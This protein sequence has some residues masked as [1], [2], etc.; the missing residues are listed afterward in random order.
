MRF[1][2]TMLWTFDRTLGR[3]AYFLSGTLLFFLKFGIDW[4]IA[5]LAFD[6]P[7]TPLNYLIWPNDR[8]LRIFDL[9]APD[10][11]FVLTMLAVS[12]PFIWAGVLLTLHR[13]GDAGLPRGLVLFFFV[14]LVNLL[15]F[16]LLTL[17]PSAPLRV[18]LVEVPAPRLQRL[19]RA[20]LQLAGKSYWR[21]GLVALALS[22]PAM[23]LGVVL[24][25]QVLESYG[26]SLFVGAP[27]ALGLLSVLL[28]GLSRPQP[29]G[30]CLIVAVLAAWLAGLAMLVV[31]LEGLIC[32]IMAAPIVSAL[33]LFGGLVGYLIQ[34]RPW[35]NE[36]AF[37]ALLGVLLLL[38]ALMAAEAA[39]EPDAEVRAVRTAVIVAAP[40]EVVWELVLAFPPLPEP[41]DWFFCTGVAYPQRA[42]IHGHGVGAVRHCI[43]S[44][45]AFVEPIEVWEPPTCLA[46]RVTEQPEPL[47]EWSPYPIHPPHLD[48]YLVSR[49]GQFLLERLPDGR[50][51]LE[52]TTWYTNRMWPAAYWGLWSDYVIQRIHGRVLEHIR[53]L[54]EAPGAAAQRPQQSAKPLFLEPEID[55]VA[56]G[57]Q[58]PSRRAM[59]R[60]FAGYSQ[61][62]EMRDELVVAR[63]SALHGRI[64][65]RGS[66]HLPF[67]PPSLLS[68]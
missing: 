2:P 49:Q 35:L 15:F 59:S 56:N 37:S 52:G 23:V 27:F 50:T 66:P 31:A 46:F 53:A 30:A 38:P 61:G 25:A 67:S 62:R 63:T 22:V 12:L 7:W 10:H 11:A 3:A 8:T 58:D 68:W 29:L 39:N 43:F 24:G 41:E 21:S 6:Q 4:A 16:V 65:C 18:V 20:H 44:T 64:L 28:F 17:L 1:D 40:P 5:R 42:E 9:T 14:P 55:S 51:R 13:L 48:N 26:F 36:Q 47:R 34:S 54:A 45:G 33:A 57:W 32:L 60:S 19:R